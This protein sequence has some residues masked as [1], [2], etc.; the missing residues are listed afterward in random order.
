MNILIGVCGF[1]NGHSARQ[2]S[3]LKSLLARGH[4]VTLLVFDNSERYFQ[5]HFPDI[6]R[7]GVRVPVIHVNATGIDFGKN[8]AEPLNRFD[9]GHTLNFKAMQAVLDTF[10]DP[11]DLVIAD[12]ELVAAQFAYAV[13]A[14]LI[15]VDQ[16]SKY[17]GFQFPLMN[18]Y[19]RL[20]DRSRLGMFF[21][22][23]E[24]RYAASFFT[25]DYPPDP[26]FAVTLIPPILREEVLQ[27]T[28]TLSQHIVVY[29]SANLHVQH[30]P[31]AILETLGAFP[32]QR[33]IVY[34]LAGQTSSNVTFKP[35]ST[36]GFIADIAS[37]KAVIT[38]GGHNLLSE[39]MYLGKPVYTLPAASF[40]QQCC[41]DAIQRNG[42]G[43]QVDQFSTD[44]LARFLANLDD[45]RQHIHERRGL[46][47]RFDGTAYLME[48]LN[49]QFGI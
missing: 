4:R 14:P 28:P 27:V 3:V 8:A 21:P 1:G 6:P 20:E 17:A 11:P 47:E 32:E 25:V 34:G 24:A 19:S 36:T 33:F 2:A 38:N 9:D 29:L 10:G 30:N 18:G 44:S 40:D 37:A 13:D 26:R 7:F 31:N 41:A 43:L 46:S 15:T 22:T 12:Y 45:Y 5:R 16:H 35:F 23:A 39:L 42:L 49:Q 48:R